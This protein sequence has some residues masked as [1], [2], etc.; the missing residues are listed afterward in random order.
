M[1]SSKQ[2]LIQRSRK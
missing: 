1:L 2:E